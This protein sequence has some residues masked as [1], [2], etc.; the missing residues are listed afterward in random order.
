[1]PFWSWQNLSRRIRLMR[2]GAPGFRALSRR[3]HKIG[4]GDT[5][6]ELRSQPA[7]FIVRFV[8]A[9]HFGHT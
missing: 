2:Q 7:R 5:L 8:S 9:P 4:S 1:M 3:C 6:E